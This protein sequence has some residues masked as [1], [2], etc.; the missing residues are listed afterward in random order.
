MLH[1]L[2]GTADATMVGSK[3]SEEEDH[4]SPSA[5]L[6]SSSRMEEERA[7]LLAACNA[8]TRRVVVKRP[9]GAEPLGLSSGSVSHDDARN[10]MD[11][12]KPSYDI[13][14]SVNRFD[15]YII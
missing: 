13:R 4:S 1:S 11:T 6:T 2:L 7:L 8:A 5:A 10:D 12:P 15:V 9:I 3:P 14:G